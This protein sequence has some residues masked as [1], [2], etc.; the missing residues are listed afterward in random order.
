M[1]GFA[2]MLIA[3]LLVGQ[4]LVAYASYRALGI[5][6]PGRDDVSIRAGSVGGPGVVGGGPNEGK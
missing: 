5:Q 4:A 2:A 6:S 1:R 3:A